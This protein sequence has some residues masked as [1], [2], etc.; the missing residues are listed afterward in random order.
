MKL[1]A[2]VLAALLPCL[3]SGQEADKGKT[4]GSPNA[5]VLIQIFSD[6]ECPACKGFHEN[7]LPL[8]MRDFVTSGKVC[9]VSHEFPLNIPAHKYSRQA[10]EYATAAARVGKYDA[11]A[12]KLFQT[13]ESWGASGKVWETVAAVLTPDQQKRVQALAKDPSVLKEVQDDVA[14]ATANGVNETPTLFMSRGSRRYPV[15]GSALGYN[16]LKSMVDDFL[17]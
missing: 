12:N 1:I 2:A 11:V 17:R 7:T 10:A 13:Q 16:L 9:I 6:F 14:Y 5:P 15:A 8:L 4:L 3:A